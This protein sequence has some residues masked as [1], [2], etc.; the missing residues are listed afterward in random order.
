[1]TKAAEVDLARTINT[2]ADY[3][4]RENVTVAPNT[5]GYKAVVTMSDS[6]TKLSAPEAQTQVKTGL[7]G[8][9]GRTTNAGLKTA[10]GN[11]ANF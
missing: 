2:T 1:M 8:A 6:V 5:D 4:A 9:Q 10:L 7:T 11:M 3:L